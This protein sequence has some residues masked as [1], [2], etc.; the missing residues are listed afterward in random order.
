MR[1]NTSLQFF[2]LGNQPGDGQQKSRPINV[3]KEEKAQFE[4]LMHDL[5]M[6]DH[7]PLQPTDKNETK[8]ESK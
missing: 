2:N 5:L 6:I 3:K 8:P 4:D 1:V 7:T